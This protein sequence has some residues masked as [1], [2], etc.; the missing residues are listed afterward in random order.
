MKRITQMALAVTLAT[1]LAAGCATDSEMTAADRP[2][3][4]GSRMADDLSTPVDEGAQMATQRPSRLNRIMKGLGFSRDTTY[5]AVTMPAA[6]SAP[7]GTSVGGTLAQGY[8]SDQPR[9]VGVVS[10]ADAPDRTAGAVTIDAA[11]G[12]NVAITPTLVGSDRQVSSTVNSTV[13][14]SLDA[15]VTDA[16]VTPTIPAGGSNVASTANS[17]VPTATVDTT[18]QPMVRGTV[19]PN[20]TA[21]AQEMDVVVPAGATNV[22]VLSGGPSIATATGLRS[23]SRTGLSAAAA[24][25][26]GTVRLD[27]SAGRTRITNV[28][29]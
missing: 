29:R 18:S 6:E 5:P 23:I 9:L 3:V 25:R 1:G 28:S 10:A 21:A 27:T 19:M 11:T 26:K 16:G 12:E 22:T 4:P 17:T 14:P 2:S 20:A 7:A 15:S 24:T 8:Y 13:V